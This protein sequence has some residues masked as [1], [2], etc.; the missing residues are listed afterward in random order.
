LAHPFDEAMLTGFSAGLAG[1]IRAWSPI[2]PAGTVV[3]VPP[4]GASAPGPYAADALGRGVAEALGLRFAEALGRTDSKRWHG[5][6]HSLRQ[7][8]FRW[9]LPGGVVPPMILVVDDL[10]TSGATV[11]RSLEAVRAAGI[12]AFA[13]AYSGC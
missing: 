4:Q 11:Q 12:M 7:A 10:V 5:P 8:S 1:L 3:T 2:L 13:F 6:H 9:E